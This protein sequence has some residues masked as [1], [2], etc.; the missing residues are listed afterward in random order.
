MTKLGSGTLTLSG[1]NTYSGGTTIRPA[2]SW[3]TRP[4]PSVLATWSVTAGAICDL[5]NTAGA[6]ADPASVYLTGSGRL[7]LAAGVS[8]SVAK[9]YIDGVL[10]KTGTWNASRDPVHFAGA[11]ELIV[12]DGE[13]LTPAEIWRQ[14]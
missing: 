5:R 12:T 4:G 6:V 14:E 3:Q 8:E 9:L 10:A 1:S 7:M 2:R 13:P 11:G